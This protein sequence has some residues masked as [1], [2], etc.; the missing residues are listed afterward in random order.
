MAQY[1]PTGATVIKTFQFP[2]TVG[3]GICYGSPWICA[4]NSIGTNQ[5]TERGQRA[6]GKEDGIWSTPSPIPSHKLLISIP[7]HPISLP[8]PHS[9]LPHPFLPPRLAYLLWFQCRNS[10]CQK[11]LDFLVPEGLY[12]SLMLVSTEGYIQSLANL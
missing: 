3:D 11:A 10:A 9:T 7:F 5:R 12:S 2:H 4:S 1:I 8:P 6:V